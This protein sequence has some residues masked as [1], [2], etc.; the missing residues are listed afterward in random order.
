MKSLF[1]RILGAFVIASF[2]VG[3]VSAATA[4]NGADLV[5]QSASSGTVSGTAADETGAPVVAA[6]V[7][8][9]GPHI[10]TASTDAKGQFTI[11]DVVPGLYLVTVRKAGYDTA[12]QPDTAIIAGSA[13]TL[14]INMHTATLTSLRTIASVSTAG[15]GA[16]NTSTAAA[17]NVSAQVFADQGQPQVVRVLNQIPGVQISLPQ[18]SANGASPGAITFPNVRG[19]LS[20]ETAS[21]ID[22]HPVSVG[23]YGD[24]VTS[25]LSPY[26]LQGV[27]VIKGPGAM[28]PE[29]NYAI[30]GTVNFRTKDPTATLTPDYTMG[31]DNHGGSFFNFGLSDTIGKL[32]FVVDVAGSN[33]TNAINNYQASYNPGAGSNWVLTNNGVTGTIGYNDSSSSLVPGTASQYYNQF[34][35][36]ACCFGLSGTFN[37]LNEL[38]K[39]RYTFSSATA[40]TVSYMGSQTLS[41]QNANTGSLSPGLFCPKNTGYNA[42]TNTNGTCST[43]P[44]YSGALGVGQQVSVANIFP[45]YNREINNEPILQAEVRSTI[46]NDTVLARFYHAGIQR[47]KR[48]GGDIA[49]NPT[50]YN[51]TLNGYDPKLGA[52]NN[53]TTPVNVYDWYNNPEM[54][55]LNGLSLE[56]DH[57]IGDNDISI[58]YDQT[59]SSTVSYSQGV[60]L[61]GAKTGFGGT[62]VSGGVPN[63]S[64]QVFSTLLERGRFQI[65]PK[66]SGVVSLYENRYQTTY[67]QACGAGA[68]CSFDYTGTPT[69]SPQWSTAVTS[70]FDQRFAL[71]YRPKADLAVRLSAGS[72]IAPPYVNLFGNYTQ[73]PNVAN[74]STYATQRYSNSSIA[75]ETAFG[76]DLGAD[77]RL[78]DGITVVSA[79]VY[80]TNLFNQFITGFTVPT[81]LTCGTSPIPCTGTFTGA[82]P[83]YYVENTN[84]NN[85]RYEGIEASIKHQVPIG[86]SYSL[87]GSVQ[88]AFAYNLPPCFYGYN[89]TGTGCANNTL[90]GVVPGNNFT[91]G[92]PGQGFLNTGYFGGVSNQNIP[93]LQGNLELS[94][95]FK[96]NAQVLFGDTLYGKNNSLNEPPFGL[97]YASLRYPLSRSLSVQISGDNIFA[98]YPGLFPI[99]GNGVPVP[100]AGLP[101]YLNPGVAPLQAATTAGVLGPANWRFIL[102]KNIG[103]EPVHPNP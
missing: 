63:G 95:T 40:A 28:S 12:Q 39:F 62:Y 30:G 20:F 57:P 9:T 49:S 31:L 72:A 4:S 82:T 75:P 38:V 36:V 73:A 16:I 102:T 99:V 54:D 70:H 17:T 51:L 33:L 68:P 85:S 29:V 25:F 98:A 56:Y 35:V 79:D 91:G 69:N 52:F 83:I 58:A 23:Q 94:Y 90:L 43:A 46:G 27:D 93:Y 26:M 50:V 101:S 2:A 44:G 74:G 67:L 11:H 8:L 41:D 3:P 10:Y 5:A 18:S 71:E 55:S 64:S 21:L 76:F 1:A 81:N 84:L 59:H 92:Q 97:A 7:T 47:L 60:F 78:H 87:S 19:G 53:V 24:Y 42:K 103:P 34:G 77:Y 66:L 14:A 13:T 37:G 89:S 22:G 45:V 100:I 80:R 6:T 32:G 96:N 61:N 15:R 48:E 88:H 86:F 65:N